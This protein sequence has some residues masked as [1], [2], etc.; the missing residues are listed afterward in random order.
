MT[1]LG[2]LNPNARIKDYVRSLQQAAPEPEPFSLRSFMERA[3]DRYDVA[4]MLIRG[5]LVLKG[6]ML[7]AEYERQLTLLSE[8]A[9]DEAEVMK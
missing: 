9:E 5:G 7:A 8:F 1:A 3:A 6:L 2:V 4:L